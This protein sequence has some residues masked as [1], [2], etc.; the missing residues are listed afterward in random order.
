MSIEEGLISEG[1]G[2]IVMKEKDG[3]I[4]VLKQGK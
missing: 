4:T 1:K 3:A 2:G